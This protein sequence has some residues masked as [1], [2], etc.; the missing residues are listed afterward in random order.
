MNAIALNNHSISEDQFNDTTWHQ[1]FDIPA[2]LKGLHAHIAQKQSYKTPEQYTYKSY[3]RGINYFIQWAGGMTQLALPTESLINQYI[4]HL[5]HEKSWGTGKTV[6]NGVSASTV[7]NSYLAP[8]RIFLKKLTIQAIPHRFIIN[9][10]D[11]PE[12]VEFKRRLSDYMRDCKDQINIALTI[13]NPAPHTKSNIAPLWNA[14]FVR[15]NINQVNAVLES[16]DQNTISGARD[17]LI[18]RIAFET[19]LRI[20]ELQRITR[21]SITPVDDHYDITVRGKRG[22]IDPVSISADCHTAIKNYINLYNAPL[23]PDDPRRITNTNPIFQP[24]RKGNRHPEINHHYNHQRGLSKS[25]LRDIISKHTAAV[26]GDDFK[27]DPHDCRRTFAYIA[28]TQGMPITEISK[29][30]RHKNVSITW[31]Y[32][33]IQPDTSKSLLTNYVKIV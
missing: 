21:Q 1:L 16:L 14:K 19:G 10:Q 22:N 28:F 33:G 26:L 8:L 23:D 24:L 15:L 2:A 6:K 25:G 27:C 9:I 3:L 20:A 12:I 32:I 18:L 4:A 30:L 13:K 5:L 31:T 7:A 29:A 17:Y 11:T